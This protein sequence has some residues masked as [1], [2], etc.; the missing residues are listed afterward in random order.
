MGEK[1]D[2][3]MESLSESDLE[4]QAGSQLEIRLELVLETLSRL[5][6]QVYSLQHGMSSRALFVGSWSRGRALS[7]SVS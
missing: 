2:S 5:R 3:L 7:T 4:L 1:S 6:I